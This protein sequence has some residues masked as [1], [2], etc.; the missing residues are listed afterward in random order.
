MNRFIEAQK[1]DYKVALQ[2][3]KNGKK[4]KLTLEVLEK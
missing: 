4:C 1:R 2:E 3:V